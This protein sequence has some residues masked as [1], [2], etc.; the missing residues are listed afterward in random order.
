M[1]HLVARCVC[2]YRVNHNNLTPSI[3]LQDNVLAIPVIKSVKQNLKIVGTC[4]R[5][6][7]EVIFMTI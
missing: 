2:T 4:V 7:V 5:P 1:I 3:F 6:H